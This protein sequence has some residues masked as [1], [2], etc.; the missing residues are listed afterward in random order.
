MSKE[1]IK[2]RGITLIALIITIIVML[3]L[4]GVTL[5]IILGDNGLVNKAKTVSEEMQREMDRELLLSAVVGTMGNDGKVKLSAIN[6]PEGFTGSNGTYTSENGNEFTVNE[7]GE[8][9]YT[10]ESESGNETE[11]VDL[12]GK[13]Y[14]DF[15]YTEEYYEIRN[16]NTFVLVSDGVEVLSMPISIDYETKTAV[17]TYEYEDGSS[18]IVKDTVVC[19]YDYV[20]ENSEI[21]NK[22]IIMGNTEI[23]FQNKN[24]I[25]NASLDGIY[26]NEDGDRR[27]VFNP[28][29]GTGVKEYLSNN[30]I[31]AEYTSEDFKYASINEEYFI[32]RNGYSLLD[33]SEDKNAII[34]QGETWTKTN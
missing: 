17:V 22:Y 5:S 9:L 11:T 32:E 4:T 2:N 15:N 33:F 31:W 26:V 3:I 20:I 14:Y 28:N 18:G 24:G 27:L 34:Y 10:G 30:G 29:N 8:I 16:E 1:K 13:Y 12:N 23:I 19:S 6:L 21:I 7:N 25:E